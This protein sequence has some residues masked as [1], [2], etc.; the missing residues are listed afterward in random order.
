MAGIFYIM[1]H[2]ILAFWLVLAYDLLED[3]RTIDVIITKFFPLCFKMAENFNNLDN[4]LRDWA[5]DKVQK[6][7]LSRHWTGTRSSNKKDQTVSFLRNGLEKILEQSQSTVERDQ[8]K[9]KIG[10]GKPR[11]T[12][13]SQI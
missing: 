11:A 10:L 12:A 1:N 7:V 6:K 4:I 8:T 5:K 2:V 13:L 3:R 9:H